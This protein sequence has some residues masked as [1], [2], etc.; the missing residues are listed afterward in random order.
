MERDWTKL[1]MRWMRAGLVLTALDIVS[2]LLWLQGPSTILAAVGGVLWVF[3]LSLLA[4]PIIILRRAGGIP[5][6][7]PFINTTRLVT[8]GLFRLVRHPQYLGWL[9][10]AAA[11]PFY[12]QEPASV[13][14]ALAAVAATAW[15]LRGVDEWERGVFGEAYAEYMRQVPGF[16]LP[17]GIYRAL[18]R[19]AEAGREG[20]PPH[21]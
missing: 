20:S 11:V 21:S 17:A 7:Q 12:T 16:N 19:R 9:V 4:A 6:G 13:A 15:G 14:L 18:T 2:A 1:D 5:P 3:G 8:T 10:L